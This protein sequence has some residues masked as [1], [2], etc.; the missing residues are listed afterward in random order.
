MPP[1]APRAP[2]PSQPLSRRRLAVAAAVIAAGPVFGGLAGC[3]RGP[4]PLRVELEE[5]RALFES[6][7]VL[8]FDIRESSEHATGV[9]NGA[10]LLPMSQL[11]Q[12]LGEI[13]RDPQQPVLIICNTQNRS[14]K[15]VQAMHE[16]G[17]TNV[18]YVHGGM[19]AW[20]RNGWPMVRPFGLPGS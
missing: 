4:D 8:M 17:W 18:R 5:G 1:T 19:S 14:S 13:P 11:Q 2:A 6:R 3:S 10:R 15:V 20:A 16:A 12:R 9:A 7:Q